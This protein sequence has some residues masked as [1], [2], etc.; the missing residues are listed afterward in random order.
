MAVNNG[1]SFGTT[2]SSGGTGGGGNPRIAGHWPTVITYM[3][4]NQIPTPTGI[5]N[6]TYLWDT[7]HLDA[8]HGDYAGNNGTPIG[9]LQVAPN[10]YYVKYELLETQ[11]K[12]DPDVTALINYCTNVLH[13]D[14]ENAFYHYYNDTVVDTLDSVT[15][16]S[17]AQCSDGTASLSIPGWG[18][19]T[20]TTRAQAR[21]QSC[22][23]GGNVRYIW[24]HSD[25]TCLQPYMQHRSEQD[26]T[27][28]LTGTSHYRGIFWDEFGS[29]SGC[30]GADCLWA[31]PN[32]ISGGE[33]AELTNET[34]AQVIT[35]GK[36]ETNLKSLLSA[37]Q[38][39]LNTYTTNDALTYPNLAQCN[40]TSCENLSKAAGMVLTE[41]WDTEGV[42]TSSGLGEQNMW[43]Y[44]ENIISAG[45]GFIWVEG[46]YNTPTD[47]TFNACDYTSKDSRHR[48]WALTDYLMVK[49]NNRKV[50]YSQRPQNAPLSSI[51]YAAQEH[52]IGQPSGARTQLQTGTTT[53]GYTFAI[54]ER[55]YTK[56]KIIV[57]SRNG[58]GTDTTLD[59]SERVGTSISL[60]G[61]YHVLNYDNTLG[62]A[63]TSIQPCFTEAVTLVQN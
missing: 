32:P 10:F 18:G 2:A 37:V 11:I 35:D 8:A 23:D 40:D 19:G 33:I 1:I 47:A 34:K 56:G 4:M 26:V 55:D 43:N 54:Y 58:Y 53:G 20:A 46:D 39:D 13:T 36:Y 60:G 28:I 41:F 52:D 17:G 50:W 6:D 24:N 49:D 44:A 30:S 9:F 5:G 7:E 25:T 14:P 27:T 57:V 22:E 15:A 16:G 21:I 45:A 62:P 61:T 3:S 12:T 31:L 59:Y 51:W 29:V 63:I 42:N 48:M 38:S